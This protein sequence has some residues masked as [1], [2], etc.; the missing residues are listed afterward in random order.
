MIPDSR[1]AIVL[2]NWFGWAD[3]VACLESL[4]AQSY[5]NWVAV[6]VDNGS[7]DGSLGH[8][9]AAM[10]RLADH[11][12]QTWQ[13]LVPGEARSAANQASEAVRYVLIDAGANLG[14]AGGNNL[15]IEWALA[16]GVEYVWIL[17]NDTEVDANALSALVDRLRIEGASVAGSVLVFHDDRTK[18]QCIGGASYDF[19]LARGYQIGEGQIFDRQATLVEPENLSYVAGASMLIAS[20]VLRKV[21]GMEERYFLYFEELDWMQRLRNFGPAVV[22]T[23]SIVYHKEGASIGTASRTVRSCKSQFYMARNLILFYR[24]HYPWLLPI[25]FLRNVREMIRFASAGHWRHVAISL[26]A[27]WEA[28]CGKSGFRTGL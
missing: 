8:I 17:N 2:V 14:F 19:R 4:S 6:V 9:S 11:G 7:T 16:A 15:G 3:T 12:D 24:W 5:D 26:K 27:S 21:G 13:R 18:I 10:Q 1:V 22:A 23:D 20:D 28:L 25:A